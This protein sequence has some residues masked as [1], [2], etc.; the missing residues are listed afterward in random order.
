MLVVGVALVIELS[1]EQYKCTVRIRGRYGTH[2]FKNS[3]FHHALVEISRLILDHFD[4]DDFMRL[5]V[6]T[7]DD[8]AER[9]LPEDVENE[10]P[11]EWLVCNSF[12]TNRIRTCVHHL[13]PTNH[14]H[15]RC[16]RSPRYHIHHCV[17]ACS[18]SSTHGA[19]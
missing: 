1:T 13:C 14:S 7:F 3:N 4:R 8:L 2:Q 15:T 19:G 10:V 11:A 5:H 12:A 18:V 6:L 17:M 16:N 9:S